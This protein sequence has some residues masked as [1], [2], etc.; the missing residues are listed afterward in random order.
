MSL[1]Y[2]NSANAG[3]KSVFKSSSFGPN[4]SSGFKPIS[5]QKSFQAV[6]PPAPTDFTPPLPNEPA[7][8]LPHEPAPPPPPP[9]PV[10]QQAKKPFSFKM[11]SSGE[12]SQP[13]KFGGT[14]PAK[15]GLSFCLGKKKCTNAIQFGT[16]S[17]PA[18]STAAAFAESSSEDE[19]EEEMP[20]E[21]TRA[22]FENEDLTSTPT[23]QQDTL[24]K[25]IEYADTLKLKEALRPKL[26]IRFVKGTEQGGVLP[27]TIPTSAKITDKDKG[28]SKK[29]IN[30]IHRKF[31]ERR[32]IKIKN[33]EDK[34]KDSGNK[35]RDSEDS[36]QEDR[37]KD[38]KHGKNSSD[39]GVGSERTQDRREDK[40]RYKQ[41]K[42]YDDKKDYR[43][44]DKNS[45]D[46]N[47]K[48]ER[49]DFK[50]SRD[51]DSKYERKSS[52]KKR[53]SKEGKRG[54]RENWED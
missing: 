13:E 6:P 2:I 8:P 21:D 34:T 40:Y 48:N 41:S 22:S 25:V 54:F 29:E 28:N 20:A 42:D 3:F 36:Y 7:P 35:G 39:Q 44:R 4:S 5:V 12:Q 53:D 51:V 14:A 49:Y 19:E 17:K 11:G 33:E 10:D 32:E 43:K 46:R 37:S 47:R 52:S 45:R 26:L 15:Q 30:K 1:F 23:Q 50:E 38:D 24:K 18:K 31:T 16:K 9:P 27:G